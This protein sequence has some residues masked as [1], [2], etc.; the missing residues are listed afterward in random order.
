[1]LLFTFTDTITIKVY[2]FSLEKKVKVV[3]ID[4]YDCKEVL[5]YV[6]KYTFPE[7]LFHIGGIGLI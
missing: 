7:I 5:I 1:M 2:K 4:Q 3:F 6:Y